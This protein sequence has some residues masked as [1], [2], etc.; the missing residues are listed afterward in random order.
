MWLKVEPKEPL[1][2]GDVRA[3]PQFLAG[4]TYLPGRVLR[5][6][7]AEWLARSGMGDA[8]ILETV[9]RARIGNFFPAAEWRP[10]RYALPLPMSA[11]SCKP[12]SGFEGEPLPERRGHGVVDTLL[13][14][15][16]YHLLEERG[17]RF[18]VPFS[19]VCQKCGSRTE[20]YKGFY[21]VY[22]DGNT[23]RYVSF[24]PIFH[25]QTKVAISRY[26]RASAEGMLYTASALSPRAFGPDAKDGG[27]ALA[28][29]GRISQVDGEALASLKEALGKVALGALH[30]RGYGRVEVKEID[31]DLPPLKER[32]EVF[33]RTLK[34]LWR[35]IR[36][37]A[38]NA[39]DLAEEPGGSYFSVDLL[40]PG[41]FQEQGIPT[42]VL[43]LTTP[44]QQLQPVSWMTRP[45]IASGWSTAWGL[46]KPT[47]LA[48]RMG[49]VYVFRWEGPESALVLTLEALEDQ[50]V[51]ERRDE[52]FGECLICHPFH[53]EVEEA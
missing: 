5:G 31:I 43:S 19:A 20:A 10:I 17:A 50:G 40:A 24:R 39:R 44:G 2:P 37:L 22:R 30:T 1:I 16:A 47:N 6:A 26:R 21:T 48:A 8:E 28:F 18:P 51:G 25:G 9:G 33:N 29:V 27:T 35:D 34:V 11:V 41:V 4:Q 13:P 7:W 49:S 45:D 53:M 36:R 15:L 46:P 14:N 42:L 52:S 23:D 38:V 32:L 12:K 3:D